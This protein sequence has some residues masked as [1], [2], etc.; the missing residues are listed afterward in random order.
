MVQSKSII[1]KFDFASEQTVGEITK[2]VGLM[3]AKYLIPVIDALNLEA[4]PRSS[5]TGSVTDAIQES[6][7]TDPDTFPFKTKGI[8]LASSQY[9]R[10]ER[11]RYRILASDPAIEG[12]LDGGHNTLAIGLFILESALQYH[13]YI[14]KRGTKT[15]DQFKALWIQ[16]RSFIEKYLEFLRKTPDYNIL[17][18]LIPVELLVPR[19]AEDYISVETFKGNLLDICTARNNNVEL[20]V[21]AKANQRGYFDDLKALMD[22]NAPSIS[23]RIEWK[24]NDGGDIKV[25]DIVALAWIPLQLI[26]PVKDEAKKKIDPVA[27]SKIYSAKGACLKQF[28]KLMSSPEVTRE[29]SSDY[30]RELSNLEVLSALRIASQLPELYDYIYE[31]FPSLY[32]AAGGKYGSITAVKALNQNRREKLTPFFERE[33]ASDSYLSPDGYITPLIYGL[34]ALM[35][36]REVNGQKE[37]HWIC[38]PKD[39]L[40]NKLGSIVANY[41]GL[42]SMCDYDPQKIGKNAQSYKQAVS[43]FKMALANIT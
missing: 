36:N 34:I 19:D 24:T 5:R 42:F 29:T 10:L 6:I 9:E 25:Q 15:W 13:G 3:R 37:I 30:K 14:L 41:I 11:N 8:L 18:F 43:A 39:F 31:S 12:I 33:M 35:E 20:Q 28:E 21:A 4:N 38:S 16:N 17:N 7:R 32:N 1:I 40:K 22:E 23:N 27:P 2:I 26:T